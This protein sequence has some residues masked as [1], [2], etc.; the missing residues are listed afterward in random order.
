MPH[1]YFSIANG[2][3]FDDVDGLDLHDAAAARAEAVGFARDLMRMEPERRDWSRWAIRVAD[4]DRQT[5]FELPFGEV[6]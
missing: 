5:L 2:R 6:A 4:G 1:Y 3:T